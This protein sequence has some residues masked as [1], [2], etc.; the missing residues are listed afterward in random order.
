M[1]K[2]PIRICGNYFTS[3]LLKSNFILRH[4]VY[5][6][7]HYGT[8]CS[9]SNT[10]ANK[11][12][13][14]LCKFSNNKVCRIRNIWYLLKKVTGYIHFNFNAWTNVKGEIWSQSH[15]SCLCSSDHIQVQ[16]TFCSLVAEYNFL[17]FLAIQICLHSC[18]CNSA[19]A[20]PW[21][22]WLCREVQGWNKVR[23][24][25]YAHVSHHLQAQLPY[26]WRRYYYR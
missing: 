17:S 2:Q 9:H 19:N 13:T 11:E 1:K 14:L 6:V 7:F 25:S 10:V 21:N 5:V 4:D 3:Y 15:T 26:T 20:V 8:R 12:V 24:I 16:F 18:K 22:V 23:G